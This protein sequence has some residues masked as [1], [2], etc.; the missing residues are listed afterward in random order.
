MGKSTDPTQ[1][2]PVTP[3]AGRWL[4]AVRCH[5]GH[6]PGRDA[7]AEQV[8]TAASLKRLWAILERHPVRG[9]ARFMVMTHVVSFE[10]FAGASFDQLP[11]APR[12]AVQEHVDRLNA[13]LRRVR[14]E[15]DW[16]LAHMDHRSPFADGVSKEL[17]RVRRLPF[18]IVPHAPRSDLARQLILELSDRLQAQTG[19]PR[20]ADVAALV[21]IALGIEVDVKRVQAIRRKKAKSAPENRQPI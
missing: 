4:R 3:A 15:V 1:P 9:E 8:A 19:R 21:S 16:V 12:H 11:W 14:R 18:L 17:T 20:D 2:R 10:L 5:P 13:A 7:R 6:W